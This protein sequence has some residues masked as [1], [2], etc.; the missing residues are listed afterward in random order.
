MNNTLAS[1]SPNPV[2]EKLTISDLRFTIKRLEI[3]NALGQLRSKINEGYSTANHTS[4]ID[5]DVS[6][7][8]PG[9][10]FIHLTGENERWVG[11]F[12]IE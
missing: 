12:V 1:I 4:Q 6:Y 3:Y 7:L 5:V 8:Q 9:I 10:Y 2:K 11:R